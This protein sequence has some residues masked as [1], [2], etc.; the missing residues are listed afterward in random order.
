MAA[1]ITLRFE[2]PYTR[3]TVATCPEAEDMGVYLWTVPT[4][5]GEL[6]QYVGET[7]KS[8]R[9]RFAEHFQSEALGLYRIDDVAELRQGRRVALWPGVYG[10]E[11][12]AAPF[13]TSEF[14]RPLEEYLGLVRFYLA[15]LDASKRVRRRIEGALAKSL[16][17][18]PAPVGTFIDK[19]VRYE[20][21]WRSE[22]PIEVHLTCASPLRG[23][24]EVL[25]A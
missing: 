17:S 19:Y 8:F 9:E 10:P 14:A 4:A 23:F 25:T 20:G 6:V 22:E 18:Q 15:R 2:G 16:K 11:R 13:V 7:G 1:P 5:F 12:T 21:R 3:S 24:P